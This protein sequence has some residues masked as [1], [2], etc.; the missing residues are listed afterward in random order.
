[1]TFGLGGHVTLW[2]A[3]SPQLNMLRRLIHQNIGNWISSKKMC[4]LTIPWYVFCDIFA[5]LSCPTFLFCRVYIDCLNAFVTISKRFKRQNMTYISLT[6][7]SIYPPLRLHSDRDARPALPGYSPTTCRLLR[8][9]CADLSHAS[10]CVT[11]VT[12]SY[13]SA[14]TIITGVRIPISWNEEFFFSSI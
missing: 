10:A 13:I 9:A 7:L 8:A 5:F 6:H 4:I 14:T 2:L 11:S 1:M 3:I 12:V